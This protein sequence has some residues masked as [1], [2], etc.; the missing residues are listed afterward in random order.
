MV[1]TN[2]LDLPRAP[3]PPIPPSIGPRPPRPTNQDHISTPLPRMND[4]LANQAPLTP[5][6]ISQGY[7][8]LHLDTLLHHDRQRLAWAHPLLLVPRLLGL[9]LGLFTLVC[10]RGAAGGAVPEYDSVDKGFQG[11]DRPADDC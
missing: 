8:T 4:I 9:V 7:V 6:V 11:R 5:R 1:P 3:K 10:V 2:R